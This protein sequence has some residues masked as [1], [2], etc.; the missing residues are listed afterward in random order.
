MRLDIR[1]K[2]ENIFRLGTCEP[3]PGTNPK[4]SGQNGSEEN[5][6]SCEQTLYKSIGKTLLRHCLNPTPALPYF[7]FQ[8]EHTESNHSSQAVPR[9][10]YTG[11]VTD[12]QTHYGG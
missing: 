4:C 7:L 8:K 2:E 11:P 6:H 5:L 10:L 3:W 1:G 12:K 9:A